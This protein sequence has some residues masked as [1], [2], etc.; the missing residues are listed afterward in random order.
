MFSNAQENEMKVNYK[1]FIPSQWLKYTN[2][3]KYTY[4]REATE[5]LV[6]EVSLLSGL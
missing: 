3:V 1:E 2:Q 6:Y 5:G 4:A